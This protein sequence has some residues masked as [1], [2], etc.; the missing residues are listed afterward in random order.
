MLVGILFVEITLRVLALVPPSAFYQL[1][2]STGHSHR[3]GARGWF[4][5]EG[6]AFIEINGQGL[7]GPEVAESKSGGLRIAVLGDSFV[8]AFQVAFDRAFASVLER[9]LAS[10][11]AQEVE[12]IGFGVS[13]YGTAQELLTLR[14]RVWQYQPDIIVLAFLTGND[15]RNN[16]RK[17]DPYLNRPYFRLEGRSLVLDG[18]FRDWQASRRVYLS[19][20]HRSALLLWL[21]RLRGRLTKA[22]RDDRPPAEAGVDERVYKEPSNPDWEEAWTITELLLFE[23]NREVAKHG[24]EL[25]IV[26]LSNGIQ[27][28][29]DRSIREGF[30]QQIGVSDLFYPDH[31]IADFGEANGISVLS[32]APLFQKYADEHRVFLHGFDNGQL[33]LGHWNEKGHALAGEVVAQ[34]LC[35]DLSRESD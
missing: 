22:W 1:D 15:I 30:A 23:I 32:L 17:L 6:E 3:P 24:A 27:V 4:R 20:V 33:G 21:D 5:Q 18:E 26:T 2:P 13:D 29:P 34:R 16:S 7:R 35:D 14:E 10:S 25:L 28:H 8:E 31:R 11:C 19:I 12:I 9:E